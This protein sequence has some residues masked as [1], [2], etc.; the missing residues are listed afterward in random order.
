MGAFDASPC[1]ASQ[2]QYGRANFMRD[3]APGFNDFQQ[4]AQFLCAQLC[5][6]RF[7][8]FRTYR[9]ALSWRR[10]VTGSIPARAGD[11]AEPLLFSNRGI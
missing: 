5:A 9:L 4:L 8:R 2:G 10:S 11:K 6:G 3:L 1:A 7:P